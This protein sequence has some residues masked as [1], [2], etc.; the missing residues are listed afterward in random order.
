[1]GLPH[2]HW[3]GSVLRSV[4]TY[5]GYWKETHSCNQKLSHHAVLQVKKRK[6][7]IKKAHDALSGPRGR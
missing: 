7:L 4:A 1:M 6:Q 5:R 3:L 2:G